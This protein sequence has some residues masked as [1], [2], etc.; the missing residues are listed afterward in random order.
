[1]ENADAY[2]ALLQSEIFPGIQGREI[3]GYRG[4]QLC[5]RTVD[6]GV[7]FMTV[8]W[9]DSMDSVRAFAGDDAEAAVV[10]PAARALLAHFDPRS[11]HYHVQALAADLS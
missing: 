11:Q 8:M 10:P 5:R 7:E 1:M 3:S 4:I 9:F 2:E 6:D